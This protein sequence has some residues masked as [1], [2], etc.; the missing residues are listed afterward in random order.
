MQAI[1][2]PWGVTAYGAGSVKALPDLVRVRFKIVNTEPT[3]A[4]A[5]DT[6]S[7][8]V[9]GVRSALRG[10]GVPDSAVQASRLNLATATEYIDG[11]Q[12]F[13]GYRCVAAFSVDSTDLNGVQQ[14]LV[15]LVAAGVNEIGGVDFD[16]TAKRALR[17]EAR[18]K[19]VAA[20]RAK[21]ELYAEAATVRL[22]PVL[23]IEDVDAEQSGGERYRSHSSYASDA[24][25]EQDLAP[26]HIVV[27]AAVIL[28]FAIA[29]D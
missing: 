7:T 10:R 2:R 5:F 6:A 23:H 13:A 27:N 25:L 18:R 22:G 17:A 16:V 1:G 3:P 19:A 14:L 20:A 15:D 12:R 28:G 11:A 9:S 29:R 26:G 24:A 8:S 21:A 4:A